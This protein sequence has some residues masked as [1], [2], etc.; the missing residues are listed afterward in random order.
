[1]GLGSL[2]PLLEISTSK[3]D[4]T[5]PVLARAIGV[6]FGKWICLDGSS[7]LAALGFPQAIAL[8][9]ALPAFF[10]AT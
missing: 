2:L 6:K 5:N 9:D 3:L 1:M 8:T 7:G 10:F 4:L